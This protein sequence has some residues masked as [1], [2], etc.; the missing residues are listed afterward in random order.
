MFTILWTLA[1]VAV[2]ETT[3]TRETVTAQPV[4]A[5]PEYLQRVDEHVTALFTADRIAEYKKMG[6]M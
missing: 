3:K 4:E 1:T 6:L 2:T 5:K